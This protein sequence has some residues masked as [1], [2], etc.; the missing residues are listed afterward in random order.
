[1]VYRRWEA[2]Y[3]MFPTGVG[4]NRHHGYCWA[5]N[6]SEMHMPSYGN[7]AWE[8]MQ[9]MLPTAGKSMKSRACT[10]RCIVRGQ[11]FRRGLRTV[12][13]NRFNTLVLHT[14]K[15]GNTRVQTDIQ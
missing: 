1:M 15:Y 10:H 7:L 9:E 13:L 12:L 8:N 5:N 11:P 2:A 14:I 3:Q 4:M 6:E